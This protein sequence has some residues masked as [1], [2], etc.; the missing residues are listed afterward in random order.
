MACFFIR[1]ESTVTT[2]VRFEE[3]MTHV[4]PCQPATGYSKSGIWGGE[5]ICKL[6]AST[7]KCFQAHIDLSS[8]FLQFSPLPLCFSLFLCGA[9]WNVW[10]W[11]LCVSNWA[12]ETDSLT[13]KW[14]RLS[15]ESLL[16]TVL[17]LL[18]CWKQKYPST[19]TIHVHVKL[20]M[21]SF[22]SGKALFFKYIWY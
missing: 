1:A 14:P 3:S 5:Q 7:Y 13:C 8:M 22:C 15:M 4:S 12:S 17:S 19:N 18:H 20:I 10:W 11:S 2:T 21:F 6:S 9:Q 16:L